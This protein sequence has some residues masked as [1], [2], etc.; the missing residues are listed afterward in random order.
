MDIEEIGCE[1]VD[2]AQQVE[3]RMKGRSETVNNLA[4][5][6]ALSCRQGETRRFALHVKYIKSTG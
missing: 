6:I 4:T 2:W 3:Y 1:E 5:P